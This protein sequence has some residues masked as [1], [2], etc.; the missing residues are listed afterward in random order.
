MTIG[1]SLLQNRRAGGH[2]QRDW[3]N[4]KGRNIFNIKAMDSC[5]NGTNKY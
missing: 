3:F 1:I 4:T 2:S 5:P